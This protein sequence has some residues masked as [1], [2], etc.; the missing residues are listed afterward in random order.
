MSEVEHAKQ[1]QRRC[2]EV[3]DE[4]MRA[5]SYDATMSAL[6]IASSAVLIIGDSDQLART[7]LARL[8]MKLLTIW[9]TT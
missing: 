9:T 2:S 4:I 7:A 1:V 5:S 6:S 8:M 3:V